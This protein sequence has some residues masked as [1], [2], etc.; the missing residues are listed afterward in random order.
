V[1]ADTGVQIA[2]GHDTTLDAATISTKTGDLTLAAGWVKSGDER[3]MNNWRRLLVGYAES[4]AF[5]DD[6]A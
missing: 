4:I 2:A 6:V 1:D 5:E 3:L